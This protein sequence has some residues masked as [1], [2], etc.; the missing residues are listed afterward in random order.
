MPRDAM[1][2]RVLAVVVCPSPS[3]TRRYCVKTAKFRI[4]QT[5]PR[6]SPG[7]LVFGRQQSLVV[8]PPFPL[9]YA[10]KVTHPL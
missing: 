5:T 10:L 6:D 8:D 7:T 4:T 2:A 3:V 1:L 9:K